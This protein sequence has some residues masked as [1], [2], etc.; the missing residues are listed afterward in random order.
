MELPE[1]Q[2]YPYPDRHLELQAN[3]ALTNATLVPQ[4]IRATVC[5][6]RLTLFGT[7]EWAY[8]R[9]EAGRAVEDIQG[10]AAITNLINVSRRTPPIL[11]R[12]R[13]LWDRVFPV[14]IRTRLVRPLPR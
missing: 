2:D 9:E 13:D 4:D 11:S 12:L 5:N 1:N 7:T 14:R 3:A 8:V 6:R 10:L